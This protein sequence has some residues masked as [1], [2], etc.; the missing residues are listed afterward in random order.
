MKFG[1]SHPG[2]F[3]KK[4]KMNEMECFTMT[5][6]TI[7]KIFFWKKLDFYTLQC[8]PSEENKFW[9]NESYLGIFSEKTIFYFYPTVLIRLASSLCLLSILS[10]NILLFNKWQQFNCNFFYRGMEARRKW[11]E[12]ISDKSTEL[13]SEKSIF[14][15][16]KCIL[17]LDNFFFQH[18][19][20]E[21]L[22]L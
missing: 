22:W 4:M 17:L 12:F 2:G 14:H 19:N 9:S 18:L 1:G 8:V 7:L 21:L 15:Y 3:I 11:L 13:H 20:D 10:K 6:K 16:I 5:K